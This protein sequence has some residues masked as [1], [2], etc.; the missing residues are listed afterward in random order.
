MNV[1]RTR[2]LAKLMALVGVLILVG[3]I[4]NTE[5]NTPDRWL[6]DGWLPKGD[7]AL[8][9]LAAWAVLWSAAAA[10]WYITGGEKE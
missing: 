8:I 2:F 5:V 1:G 7:L 9:S 4:F 6:F 10:L 3:F